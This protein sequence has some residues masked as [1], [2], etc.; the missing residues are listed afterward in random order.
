MGALA[1]VLSDILEAD[2]CGTGQP[3]KAVF[4]LATSVL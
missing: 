1:V 4:D 3:G 2:I